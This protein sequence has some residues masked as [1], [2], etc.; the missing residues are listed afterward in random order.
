MDLLDALNTHWA[1]ILW[2]LLAGGFLL[3]W[4]LAL[5]GKHRLEIGNAAIEVHRRRLQSGEISKEEF[6]RLKQSLSNN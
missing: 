2:V 3:I 6:K 5:R 1:P 4:Y